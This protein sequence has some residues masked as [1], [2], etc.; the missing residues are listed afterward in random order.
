MAVGVHG[1]LDGTAP[2]LILDVGKGFSDTNKP[3]SE[4]VPEAVESDMPE[5][6]LVGYYLKI[7][8]RIRGGKNG[9]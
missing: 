4:R 1:Q 6:G 8:P 3:R 2:Q 5:P 7:T 9:D